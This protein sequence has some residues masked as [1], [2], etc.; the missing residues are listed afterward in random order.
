MKLNVA[1]LMELAAVL[2]AGSISPGALS[3]ILTQ[4]AVSRSLSML[5]VWIGKHL[6]LK[7]KR[8]LQPTCCLGIL[9]RISAG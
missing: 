1:R 7:G 6:F 5:E 9:R 4:S 8:P 3:L 2:D